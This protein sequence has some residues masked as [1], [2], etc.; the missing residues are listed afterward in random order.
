MNRSSVRTWI[1]LC[2]LL[3][4]CLCA[5]SA[6]SAPAY[7]AFTGLEDATAD[8][9][10]LET[11]LD[12]KSGAAAARSAYETRLGEIDALTQEPWENADEFATRV[13][14]ETDKA[15]K[16]RD[17]A[18]AA[19][20][21]KLSTDA[22]LVATGKKLAA[23]A[24]ALAAKTFVLEKDALSLS[25]GS[26]DTSAEKRWPIEVATTNAQLPW[27]GKLWYSIKGSKDMGAAFKSFQSLIDEGRLQPRLLFTLSR[28][29]EGNILVTA[30][31]LEL[32][33]GGLETLPLI[34]RLPVD[35]KLFTFSQF[36]PI[37]T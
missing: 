15:A 17:A 30:K 21:Q 8:I 31:A 1:N 35:Q 29:A 12:Q 23:A 37:L 34:A 2:A 18:L 19:A 27:S 7:T 3:F 22:A 4:F 24:T 11:E 20:K 10:A 13:R 32:L 36:V 16:A 14:A 26:F 6:Q 9:R 25:I 28:E 5:C 33:D